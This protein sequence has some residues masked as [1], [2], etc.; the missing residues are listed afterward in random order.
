MHF[1]WPLLIFLGLTIFSFTLLAI[2][3]TS[4]ATTLSPGS[5]QL[6]SCKTFNYNGDGKINLVFFGTKDAVGK[7]M[8]YFFSVSPFT[9]HKSEFN[10]Y[11][12]DDYK[13]TC[14]RYK[15]IALFCY[16]KEILEKAGS[17]PSADAIIALSPDKESIR[18]SAYLGVAS[19]NT[20]HPNSVFAHEFGHLFANFAEEYRTDTLPAS[21]PN[22]KESKE[23]F[24]PPVDGVYQEC[25]KQ[26][27]YRS[28]DRGFMR[29]LEAT[30][31]GQYDERIMESQIEKH[32]SPLKTTGFATQTVQDCASESYYL[33]S[34][35]YDGQTLTPI[36]TY[37]T[38]GCPQSQQAGT[39][40]YTES[41]GKQ[42][43]MFEPILFTDA[44]GRDTID[45]EDFKDPSL[46]VFVQL[47][48]SVAPQ[49]SFHNDRGNLLGQMALD[50]AGARLC[51]A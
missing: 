36:D 33:V 50:D 14:T 31:Y 38:N 41:N 37:I 45:G 25:S 17:C 13:P 48:S 4:K 8:D 39:F 23:G 29:S 19:I 3:S 47:P 46:P 44:P 12:I 27:Y 42:T 32:Y 15:G 24:T 28:I 6:A 34:A 2:M 7:Y 10:V 16:N 1:K 43:A 20:N 11:Y 26:D 49:I 40:S 18:S 51:R 21:Q 5:N 22:C 9:N 35:S 30:E